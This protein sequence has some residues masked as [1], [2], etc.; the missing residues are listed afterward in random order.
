MIFWL[1]LASMT[2]GALAFVVWPFLRP[3]GSARGGGDIAVYRDQLAELDRDSASGLIEAAESEA[4]RIEVSRRLLK[5]AETQKQAD[6]TAPAAASRGG[7]TAVLVLA[8]VAVPAIS[9]ALYY[10]LGAPKE[11]APK[12][13]AARSEGPSFADMIAQVEAHTKKDPNDARAWQV[14]APV[15]M[16]SG[17]FEQA[18]EAW[19]NVVRI[20]GDSAELQQNIGE[21]QMAAADGV[22]TADAKQA[23][24]RAL[25]LDATAVGARY[26]LGVAAAQDGRADDARKTWSDLLAS[27]PKDAPWA[28]TVRQALARLDGKPD[29]PAAPGP[30]DIRGMVE[31]LAE[32]LKANG[33]DPDGW[34]RLA[35][36][37]AVLREGRKFESAVADAR[38][39]LAAD[40][41]KLKRFEDGLKAMQDA[42]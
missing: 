32:R 20:Q 16:R 41:D 3:A 34:L 6:K 7:R 8:L 23:F 35:R 15:Y 40:P 11:A 38:K 4:A 26:Y 27:A 9:G 25:T 19:R 22:V 18:V 33:D 12:P 39:A 21:A 13:V 28:D 14:L 30:D 10:R 31:N 37:W 42:K 17:R 36:S 1:I 5:A 29:A 2:L 24:D